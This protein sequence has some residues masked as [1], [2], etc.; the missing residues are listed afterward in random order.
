[1]LVGTDERAD[2]ERLVI[3]SK[4]LEDIGH[5]ALTAING[6]TTLSFRNKYSEE[7]SWLSREPVLETLAYRAVPLA[8]GKYGSRYEE[9]GVPM[10]L[11]TLE[12][13]RLKLDPFAAALIAL[14]RHI[15]PQVDDNLLDS[16]GKPVRKQLLEALVD[17]LV[18]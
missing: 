13:A 16:E 5:T 11:H 9:Q 2:V 10:A 15:D 14:A 1:V 7:H 3:A 6:T 8:K 4:S 18:D 17:L 12:H